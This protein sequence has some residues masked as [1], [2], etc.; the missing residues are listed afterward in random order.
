MEFLFYA[1]FPKYG[2]YGHDMYFCLTL[3]GIYS[4]S[5]YYTRPPAGGWG[6]LVTQSLLW[7][8]GNFWSRREDRHI[9]RQVHHVMNVKTEVRRLPWE[10]SREVPAPTLCGPEV[11]SRKKWRLR[12]DLG[13]NR[14]GRSRRKRHQAETVTGSKAWK[15][16]DMWETKKGWN[17]E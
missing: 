15:K 12:W 6:D 13:N 7:S 1:F 4:I 2:Y 9:N 5:M 3:D 16:K 14:L 8:L 11:A 10:H 17:I